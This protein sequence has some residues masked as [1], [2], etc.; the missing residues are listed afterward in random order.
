MA[1][2]RRLICM[3]AEEH[4]VFD[5]KQKSKGVYYVRQK[6]ICAGECAAEPEA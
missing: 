4:V 3:I 1:L 5:P 6:R 2:I